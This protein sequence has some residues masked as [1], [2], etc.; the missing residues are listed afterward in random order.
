M[1][2]IFHIERLCLFPL[3]FAEGEMHYCGGDRKLEGHTAVPSLSQ[4][5]KSF[6]SLSFAFSYIR[7]FFQVRKAVGAVS[8]FFEMSSFDKNI[9]KTT[10]QNRIDFT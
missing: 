2:D 4:S 10:K 6:F 5:I 7:I 9:L 3:W 1:S 8:Q